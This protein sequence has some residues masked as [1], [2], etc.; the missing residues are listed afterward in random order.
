[1]KTE[2]CVYSG[3]KIF[4]GHGKRVVRVDGRQH[5]FLNAKCERSMRMRKNPRKVN[6]TVLYRRK[7]KK[8]TMAEEIQKKRTRKVQKFHRAIGTTTLQEIMAKRNMKPE[9]RRA[10]REQAIKAAKEKTRAVKAVKK[11]EKAKLKPAQQKVKPAKNVWH[12]APPAI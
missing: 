7:N 12:K 9:V 2:T 8:G 3:Y 6:W 1:M 5:T 11:A 10:Q 4:P